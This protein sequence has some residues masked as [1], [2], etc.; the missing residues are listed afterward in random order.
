M[1]A[2]RYDTAAGPRIAA[3][4]DVMGT[5]QALA[6]KTTT[7]PSTRAGRIPAGTTRTNPARVV[8]RRGPSGLAM[9]TL[10][11]LALFVAAFR[12]TVRAWRE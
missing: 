3:G 8:L 10:L 12:S 1:A 11:P 9:L 7:K 2:L 4:F 5:A 6:A